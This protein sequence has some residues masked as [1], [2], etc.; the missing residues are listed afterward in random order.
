MI[1][2]V[3]YPLEDWFREKYPTLGTSE[4]FAKLDEYRAYC[5]R[6]REKNKIA[7]TQ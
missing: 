4:M 3:P 6:I 7:A 5:A 1:T 2:Y